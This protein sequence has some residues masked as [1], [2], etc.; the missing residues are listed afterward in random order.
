[1]LIVKLASEILL[2]LCKIRYEF[3][4]KEDS[5]SVCGRLCISS[6]FPS[7]FLQADTSPQVAQTF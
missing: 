7:E 2:Q 6:E 5:L 3:K 4:H 1:M